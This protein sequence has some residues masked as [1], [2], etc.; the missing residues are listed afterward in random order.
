[1]KKQR[2]SSRL[3]AEVRPTRVVDRLV[4]LILEVFPSLTMLQSQSPKEIRNLT[5]L[6]LV[7]GKD[8]IL[9]KQAKYPLLSKNFSYNVLKL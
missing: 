4:V 9:V 8:H 2:F 7:I 6:N 5:L 1:M 3:E